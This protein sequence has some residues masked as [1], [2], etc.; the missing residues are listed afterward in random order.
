M[1][2]PPSKG[3]A[4]TVTVAD[5]QLAKAL[6]EYETLSLEEVRLVLQGKKLDR[7]LN[8]GEKLI[9][10]SERAGVPIQIAEGI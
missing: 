8:Q 5:A 1:Y 4:V 7:L 9:G 6:V 3:L 10:E 2:N